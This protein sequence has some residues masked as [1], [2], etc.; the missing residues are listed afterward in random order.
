MTDEL[1][2]S[3]PTPAAH[4]VPPVA[5]RKPTSVT[6]HGELRTDD[7]A[8]LR[9]KT[10][11][12]V[13]AY[14]EAENAY[15]AAVMNETEALQQT[16]YDEMLARIK[17]DDSQVP[18]PRGDWFYY[19]RTETGK[20][21]PIFCRKRRSDGAAEEVYFDQNEAAK[22]FEFYTLGALEVSPDH[23]YLALLV[24]TDGYEDFELQVKDLRTGAWL[25][26]KMEKLGFGLA[27]ASDNRTL[28]YCTTDA[29]KRSDQVWRHRLGDARNAD[30]SVYQDNDPLFNVGVGRT[31]SGDF[32]VI[33]SGSFTSSEVWVLDAHAPEQPPRLVTARAPE[34]EYEVDHGG[35]GFYI[36]TNR[37]GATNFKIMRTPVQSAGAREEWLPHRADAFVEGID[38]FSTHAVVVE[39]EGGLRRLRVIELAGSA[40]HSIA[41][42]DA[43]YGVFPAANPEFESSLYRFTY[44]SLATPDSVYDY[45]VVT[46]ERELRKRLEVRGGFD[47]ANYG[48]E[49]LMAP[50][51]D[52]TL[53]PVS[54]VYRKPFV[55]DG[56]RPLLEY[57]YGSYGYS[58]E[59]TFS[60][61]RVSLLDRGFVYA[62]AHVRGGQEMGRHWY[63][64][65]KMKRKMNT[66]HDFIDVA[67]FL[68]REPSTSTDRLAAHGGSAGRP[69]YGVR[70]ETRPSRVGG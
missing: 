65:G 68:V 26:D 33:Q 64:A 24:D 52:G 59:P 67:E 9:D 22:P 70:R 39:R 41:F 56:K 47:P 25:P 34:L 63:D 35:E 5:A 32:V 49:R 37:Y 18:V 61:T 48:V 23:N 15:T 1:P 51:R 12:E 2:K 69:L 45:D 14:L 62:I 58:I 13:I 44:S 54:L 28:L 20:A 50:A 46:R 42:D 27:W 53:V 8:W 17:E 31:R 6:L 19:S 29:A 66:F 3:T 57:A 4:P 21:Y 11:P 38:V 10:N 16:L 7:F 36:T 30:A 43:A 40:A 60:S 55:C